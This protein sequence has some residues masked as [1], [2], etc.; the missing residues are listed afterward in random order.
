MHPSLPSFLPFILFSEQVEPSPYV[1]LFVIFPTGNSEAK[2]LSQ[3][4]QN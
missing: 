4:M 3:N 2:M 1:R